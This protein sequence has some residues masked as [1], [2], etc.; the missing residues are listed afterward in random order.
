MRCLA[1]LHA[2]FWNIDPN[3]ER[4]GFWVLDRRLKHNGQLKFYFLGIK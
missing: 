1:K 2:H 3:I 4:G